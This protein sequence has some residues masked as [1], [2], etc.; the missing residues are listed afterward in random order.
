M[1]RRAAPPSTAIALTA[2]LVSVSCS[3]ETGEETLT[4]SHEFALTGNHLTIATDGSTVELRESDIDTVSFDQYLGGAA[5]DGNA[6][7]TVDGDTLLL[8]T[9]CTGF[10]PDCSGRYAITVP[11]GTAVEVTGRGRSVTVAGLSGPVSASL[12]NGTIDVSDTSGDLDLT[13]RSGHIRTGNTSGALTASITTNHMEI[14]EARGP[15][16]LRS[17]SGNL[18]VEDIRS[19]EVTTSTRS[20]DARLVFAE[21]PQRVE[22]TSEGSGNVRVTLPAGPETYQVVTEAHRLESEVE[23]D[24]ASDRLISVVGKDVRLTWAG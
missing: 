23:H 1:N 20:G 5:S 6:S 19:S 24:P 16:T 3:L 13:A 21:P 4:D 18:V 12:D 7:W 14:R 9:T 2:A 15:L 11:A 8:E 10:T 22:A 17:E